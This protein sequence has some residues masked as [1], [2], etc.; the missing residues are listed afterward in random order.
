VSGDAEFVDTGIVGSTSAQGMDVFPRLCCAVLPCVGTGLKTCRPL[1]Q[2]VLPTVEKQFR[3]LLRWSP[4]FSENYRAKGGK[5]Y[6]HRD[7][8]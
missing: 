5:R 7:S 6:I 2:E 8:F 3:N 4:K 1:V